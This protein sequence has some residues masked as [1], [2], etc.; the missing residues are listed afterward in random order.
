MGEFVFV[1]ESLLDAYPMSILSFLIIYRPMILYLGSKYKWIKY[2]IFCSP[3]QLGMTHE[4]EEVTGG[5]G[6]VSRNFT[7]VCQKEQHAIALPSLL[8][9]PSCLECK[10]DGWNSSSYLGLGSYLENGSRC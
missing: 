7:G 9:S 6:G 3:L 1:W 5:G 2:Y 10:R 8:H 4:I